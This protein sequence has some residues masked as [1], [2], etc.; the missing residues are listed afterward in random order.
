MVVPVLILSAL[1]FYF[2]GVG[3]GFSI[4]EQLIAGIGALVLL[5]FAAR[6]GMYQFFIVRNRLC[7]TWNSL[8]SFSET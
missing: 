3:F 6:R 4:F 5:F 2:T 8:A 1:A 7:S